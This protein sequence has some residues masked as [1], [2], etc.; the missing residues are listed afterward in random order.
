MRFLIVALIALFPTLSMAAERVALVIG[1]A[2]YASVGWLDHPKNDLT[3]V[4]AAKYA[5][6]LETAP[7]PA[8]SGPGPTFPAP[9]NV[10]SPRYAPLSTF[11]DCPACPEMVV[12][13][14]G[15]F[16]M[17]SPA[18]E[19][20]RKSDEGPQHRVRLRK[21]A[22]AR[23]E[24]TFDQW[25]ACVD[26]GGCRPNLLPKSAGWGRGNRPVIVVSWKDAQGFVAWLNSKVSDRPYRLPSEAEW[27][28]AAR[29]G[30]TGRFSNDAGERRLCE[31]ANHADRAHIGGWRNDAC[32]DGISLG[33]AEVGSYD[34]NGFGLHDMHG[35]VFEWVEDCWHGSYRGAPGDGSAWLSKSGGDCS[36][37]VIRGG[38]WGSPPQGLRSAF[39]V[40][41]GPRMRNFI[42]GFR[43]AR[44]LLTP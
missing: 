3:A 28:Y 20:G 1:N 31:I 38:A 14:A 23:T 17:G 8:P 7:P 5:V 15:S 40:W 11:R 37:R 12:I 30:T 19:V 41:I 9:L 32:S 39:R 16:T 25:Q 21:F 34:R 18:S 6:F 33:T 35:N 36:G 27:E 22:L 43:P 29:A 4:S 42:V 26:D 10:Q 44:T 24:V 13:P 2:E